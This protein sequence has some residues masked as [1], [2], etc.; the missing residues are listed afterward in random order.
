MSVKKYSVSA[1]TEMR[2]LILYLNMNYKKWL[3]VHPYV[4]EIS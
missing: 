3:L 1:S 4:T 2:V